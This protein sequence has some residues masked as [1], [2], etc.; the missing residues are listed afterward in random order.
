MPLPEQK[1]GCTLS[2]GVR[3]PAWF[4][5]MTTKI[6]A[7]VNAHSAGGKTGRRW[8]QIEKQMESRLGPVTTM[9]TQAPGDATR[10][11]RELLAQGFDLIAGVGGDGTFNEIVNGFIEADKPAWPQARMGVVP[12]GTGGDFQRMFGFSSPDGIAEAIQTLATGETHAID[13]GKV[14]YVTAQG[15]A[16]QRYFANLVSF[17][18]GGAVASR[19]RN[20]LTPLGGR[21]AFLWATVRVLLSYRGK[22]I[23]LSVDGGP[24]SAPCKVTNVAVGN[25]RFHGGG[26]YPCPTAVLDDGRLEITVIEYMNMFRL[27]RDIRV[28]YSGE[29]YTH[30]KIRHLRG[31]KVEAFSATDAWI[32]VDGEPLGR[33]PLAI[34][35]LP[36]I[37]PVVF[38]KERAAKMG[39]LEKAGQ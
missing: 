14:S 22:A 12:A 37:L 1:Y 26:M 23:R 36:R 19:S 25:G 13:I 17:G 5:S 24:P 35:L 3:S 38:N 20:F 29:I 27:L 34:T 31:A 16:A 10:I 6:A 18:M 15:E 9:F 2:G 28:L 33:L 11:T 32:E 7:I 21:L 30:P 8:P 4:L 39:V